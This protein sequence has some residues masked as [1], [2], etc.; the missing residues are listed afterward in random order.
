MTSIFCDFCNEVFTKKRNYNYHYKSK[1]LRQKH[2]CTECG[3]HFIKKSSLQHHINSVY[4][5]IKHKCDQCDKEFSLKD[6]LTQHQQ[7]VHEGVKYP[8]Q[9]CKL[10]ILQQHRVISLYIFIQY[11]NAGNISVRFVTRNMPHRL[12]CTDTRNLSMK[13]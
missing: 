8:C 3:N 4:K 5:N 13:V 1:H 2:G 6:S 11:M 9:Q 7:S 12:H 10:N